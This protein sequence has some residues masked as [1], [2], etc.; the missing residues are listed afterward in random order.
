MHFCHEE[1]LQILAVGL[2][3]TELMIL[4]IREWFHRRSECKHQQN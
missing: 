2:P 3:Y 1:F 4:K